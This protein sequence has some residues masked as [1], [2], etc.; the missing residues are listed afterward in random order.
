[1]SIIEEFISALELGERSGA[2]TLEKTMDLIL[3]KAR[4]HTS[5][6]A[7]SIFIVRPNADEPIELQ[8]CSLQN[9][10]V[11]MNQEMFSMPISTSSVAGYVA[12]TGETL[13]VDDLYE[14]PENMPYKFNRTFDDR[15]GYRSQSML[16]FPLKNYQG[17]VIGVVQLLNHIEGVD[18]FGA[19]RYS[20]FSLSHVDDMKSLITVLGGMVERTDLL[21]EIKRLRQE[22][23]ILKTS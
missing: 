16:A 4:R 9:D 23:E 21:F 6:E 15:D 7:G 11:Q 12:S 14:I 22:I 5:A 13:E 1:M 2:M 19:P 3:A 17:K 8:A 18:D 20:E 10:R